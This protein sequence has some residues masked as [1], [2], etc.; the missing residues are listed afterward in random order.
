MNELLKKT[1]DYR[2]YRVLKKFT[3]YA[4]RVAKYVGRYYKNL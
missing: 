3:Q 1:V 2:Y 4:S